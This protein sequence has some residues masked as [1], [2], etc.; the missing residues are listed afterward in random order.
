MPLG[1][2]VRK[3]RELAGWTLAE[4][5][6]RSGVDIGTISALERRD[7]KRSEFASALAAAFGLTVE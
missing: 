2:K 3:F 6:D 7:S 4:L 1:S 5:S